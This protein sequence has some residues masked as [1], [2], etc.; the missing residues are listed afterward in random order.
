[1][2]EAEILEQISRSIAERKE[3]KPD[4]DPYS[5]TSRELVELTGMS[6]RIINLML[7][8]MIESGD[9]ESTRVYRKTI[10]GVTA[11]TPAYRFKVE[12]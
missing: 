9:V 3:M 6:A 12:I 5:F 7:R 10:A 4:D 8:S 2:T 11:R 1:M